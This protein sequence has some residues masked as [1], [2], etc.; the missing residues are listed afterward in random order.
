MIMSRNHF[1]SLVSMCSLSVVAVKLAREKPFV[2][3]IAVH[4]KRMKE[5]CYFFEFLPT[6]FS[7]ERTADA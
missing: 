7:N 1:E 2:E 5:Y 4:L 3:G 6:A